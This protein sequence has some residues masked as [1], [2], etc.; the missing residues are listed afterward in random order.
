MVGTGDILLG[1]GRRHKEVYSVLEAAGLKMNFSR[2]HA[3]L[4]NKGRIHCQY[5]LLCEEEKPPV[6]GGCPLSRSFLIHWLVS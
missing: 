5:Q 3:C 6:V 2:K 4:K 1:K